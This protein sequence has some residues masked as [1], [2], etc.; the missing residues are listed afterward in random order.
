MKNQFTAGSAMEPSSHRHWSFGRG[1]R[2]LGWT[3]VAVASLLL[4]APQQLLAQQPAPTQR[5]PHIV[6]LITG[7]R[8][9]ASGASF[10]SVRIERAAGRESLSF[11]TQRMPVAGKTHLF[12]IPADAAPLVQSGKVDRRLFD[13]T[14]LVESR[15]DDAHR[16]NIPLIVT[17]PRISAARALPRVVPGTV[18]GRNLPSVNGMSVNS[19]KAQANQVWNTVV[20]GSSAFAA[21]REP[22]GKVWLDALQQ[23]VLDHSVPQ[24]GAPAAWELG[25]EGDG[26][27]VAVLD[28]GVDDTHP[29]LIDTVVVSENFTLDPDGDQVGHGTHVASIIAGSGA[30][31]GGLYR[32]V[33]P[34]VSLLSGKVCEG[35]GC[36]E[37]S[38]IA[39]MQWAA[40]E[41]GAQV[42]NMSLG[43]TDTPGLD[44]MEEAVETLTSQ[45]GTLFVIAAGNDGGFLP[46]S[47]PGSAAAALTV[48]AVDREDNLADFSSRGLTVDGHLKPDIAAPGV[49]IVAARAAG[50]E[51]GELVGEDYMTLSGTSMATPHVAGAAA[52][53]LQQHPTWRG[54]DVKA[55]LMGSARFN[56]AYTTADQGAGRVDVAAALG[57]SLLANASSLSFGVARW[58]HED[59]EPTVRTLTYRNLGPATELV[60]EIDVV[61]SDGTRPP[62]DMF[63]VTPSS[64]SLPEGRT[65]SVR[66]TANTRV[67]APDGLYS[68]RV[69]ASDGTRHNLAIPL[70]LIREVES[71]DLTLRHLDREGDPT[72][73][74]FDNIFPYTGVVGIPWVDPPSTLPQDAVLRLPKGRYAYES[75]IYSDVEP[76][77]L[78]RIVAPN[79]LLD[80]DKLLLLDGSATI[81]VTVVS[82]KEGAENGGVSEAWTVLTEQ[83]RFTS[84]LFSGFLGDIA[85]YRGELD[86]PEATLLSIIDTQWVDSTAVPA[87]PYIGAWTREGRLPESQ[88]VFDM[89]NLATVNGH[90]SAP[91]TSLALINEVS[92]GAF[93]RPELGFT[94]SSLVVELPLDLTA[95]LYSSDPTVRWVDQLWMHDE[96]Y[97]Q[98]IILG[99]VPYEYRA[100][101]TY[102]TRWNE[103]VFSPSLPEQTT[104]FEWADRN[105]DVLTF[106][107]PRYGDRA[108][109]G[110]FVASE[111]TTL[112]YRNGELIGDSPYDTFA[113]FEVPPE[114][115]TYRLELDH[116]QV[117]FELTPHQQVAWTFQSSHVDE[118]SPQRI[119][120]LVVRFTPELDERG[121]APSDTHFC[122]PLHV[123]QFDREAPPEVSKPSVEVSYD[124]GASWA[125]APV[126]PNGSRW[127]AFLDH[128]KRAQYVSLR[129]STH[130][131]SGNAVEQTLYRAYGLTKRH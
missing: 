70:A 57:T 37:S 72:A 61:A 117:M 32:G 58:P 115:A 16:N 77:D 75:Y 131:R 59:D 123:D 128:P 66:V 56:A 19:P 55:A 48:G 85:F 86:P 54:T 101:E 91:L 45:Y 38:I 31:S 96:E 109:H 1:L 62:A 118:G 129:T 73:Q 12:V 105:G 71:Y 47:T 89:E 3:S 64:L 40:G 114:P 82:P 100:G 5:N 113:Q 53:V 99:W 80:A 6:T 112:F 44:P 13:V 121:R 50:T 107:L 46:V 20:S 119:P 52:L 67:A 104:S 60:F 21:T 122:L 30:A 18:A 83:G 11:S 43:G 90:Y 94:S 103:P 95:H 42:I 27:I 41:E 25:Y 17:Y 81:P 120:L 8:V 24:I 35:F 84:V 108:G 39:G 127:N 36:P 33:A 106:Q 49:D 126:E 14:L 98:S 51:R 125:V 26:V 102:A 9:I 124:D 92:T 69:I 74:W 78:V 34:G 23:P 10:E 79:Q 110:G 130:D 4:G 2:A 93:W 111:G 76:F 15:Y 116:R 7:D 63:T 88:L 22:I 68:G 29:D 97:S 28:T 87:E 65:A